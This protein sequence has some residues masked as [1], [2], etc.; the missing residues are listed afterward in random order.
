MD[1]RNSLKILGIRPGEKIHEQMISSSDSYSTFEMKNSYVILPQD[2]IKL[3]KFYLKKMKAKK[4]KNGFEY[5][6]NKNGKYLTIKEIKKIMVN[7]I[8]N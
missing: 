7:Q 4:V 3:N 2:N 5:S 6:S 8:K 1:S